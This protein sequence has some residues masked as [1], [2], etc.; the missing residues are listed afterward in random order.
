MKK[1]LLSI[2]LLGAGILAYAQEKVPVSKHQPSAFFYETLPHARSMGQDVYVDE[3][4]EPALAQ[5]SPAAEEELDRLSQSGR[6]VVLRY[7]R[8]R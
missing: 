7:G 6:N 1:T 5:A 8:E 4:K 3:T 2:V